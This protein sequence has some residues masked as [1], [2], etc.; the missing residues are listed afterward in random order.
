MGLLYSCETRFA[1]VYAMLER[2]DAVQRPLERMVDKTDWCRES[3][4]TTSI[5]Q[6]ARWVRWQIRHGSWWDSMDI[7]RAVMEPAYDLLRKMDHGGLC[8]SRIVECSGWLAREVEAVVRPLDDGLADQIFRCVQERVAHMCEPVH[9]AAHLL[10][11]MRR[12]MRYYSGVVKDEDKRLMREAEQYILSQT[13]FD[14]RRKEYRDAVLQLRDFHIRTS[15]CA[16]GRE[17]ARAAVEMC[18]REQETVESGLWWSQYGGCAPELQR[19]ALRVLYMWTCSSPGERNWAIHESIHTKKRNSLLF[20][21]VPKLVEI[22]ANTRLLALQSGG[23][24]LVL[25]WTQDESILDVEGGLEADA[26]CE[27]VDH[28]IPEEDL[29]VQA[30]LWRRDACGSRLPPSIEDVFGVQAA[31]LRPYPRDDSSGDERE[32]ADEG[33]CPRG[34]GA[35]W[36]A[37]DDDDTWSDPEEVRRRSGGRDLFEDTARGRFGVEGCWDGSG[38]PL[39]EPIPHTSSP[40]VHGEEGDITGMQGAHHRQGPTG[41]GSLDR[42]EDSEGCGGGVRLLRLRKVPE[43]AKRQLIVGSES[44]PSCRGATGAG[45]GGAKIGGARHERPIDVNRE[46]GTGDVARGVA[47]SLGDIGTLDALPGN[48]TGHTEQFED[49]HHEGVPEDEAVGGGDHALVISVHA[50]FHGRARGHSA[51]HDGGE[52]RDETVVQSTVPEDDDAQS[53]APQIVDSVDT[54]LLGD[55]GAV[56]GGDVQDEEAVGSPAVVGGDAETGEDRV[57]EVHGDVGAPSTIHG[58]REEEGAGVM[59]PPPIRHDSPTATLRPPSQR[60]RRRPPRYVEQPRGTAGRPRERGQAT[61]GAV[62]S[63][64]GCTYIPWSNTRRSTAGTRKR[65]PGL[66]RRRSS[67]SST[68]EVH[69]VGFEHRGGSG[70]E[71]EGAGGRGSATPGARVSTHGLREVSQILGADVL[72]P[73]R[74][75]RPLPRRASRL[76]GET[77]GGE[78]LEMM[79]G[80]HRTDTL[81]AASQRQMR[82]GGVTVVGD[83]HT[84]VAAEG[85]DGEEDLSI[86]EARRATLERGERRSTS[87]PTRAGCH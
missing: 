10:C 40:T 6:H 45:T 28:G 67:T 61:A 87:P 36:R 82:L 46:M 15:T 41:K 12:S 53:V 75:Q 48:S 16:W 39:V 2:L 50:Q 56:P 59:A 44:P 76:D 11:P 74:T 86:H 35:A 83:D 70:A 79:R 5:R 85:A 29:D 1:S 8:M 18:V 13:G 65:Q 37:E 14:E 55:P 9:A 4:A 31:T 66:G 27:G 21:K 63:L 20:P 49:A 52:A 77:T 17:R 47:W 62:A 3:W 43:V 34:V 33:F 80:R 72:G 32:E 81:L 23:G 38:S 42:G 51:I 26:V 25:P 78:G 84:D 24:G 58:S 54:A 57:R 73:P 19:I 7:L 68:R 64:L 60:S 22:T 30:Q 69:A 71:V